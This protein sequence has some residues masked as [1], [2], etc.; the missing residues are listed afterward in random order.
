MFLRCGLKSCCISKHDQE[1]TLDEAEPCGGTLKCIDTLA[2]ITMSTSFWP[3]TDNKGA[4][5]LD[6]L[7]KSYDTDR[8]MTS[9]IS[10]SN[11]ALD[12]RLPWDD[13]RKA[14]RMVCHDILK[15]PRQL[16]LIGCSHFNHRHAADLLYDFAF[17]LRGLARL[18]CNVAICL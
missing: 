10:M 7:Y 9:D 11:A 3:L 14:A 16:Q 18:A 8:G 12:L 1:Q 6:L 17:S 5:E 2:D 15:W 13:P 4:F